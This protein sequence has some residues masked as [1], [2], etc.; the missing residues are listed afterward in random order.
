MLSVSACDMITAIDNRPA[1]ELTT[2]RIARMFMQEGKEYLL[3]IKREGKASQLK[4][5]LRRLI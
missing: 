5:K 2:D 4:I 3:S 1:P